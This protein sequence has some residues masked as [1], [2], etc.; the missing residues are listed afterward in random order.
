MFKEG[1][2]LTLRPRSTDEEAISVELS[3]GRFIVETEERDL[4]RLLMLVG[5]EAA[6][7]Q[8]VKLEKMALRL[9]SPSPRQLDWVLS[10]KAKKGMVGIAVDLEVKGSVS[11][12]DQFEA[13]LSGMD[14]RGQGVFGGMATAMIRP[15]LK[16]WNGKRFSLTALLPG[17]VR[18][19]NVRF[20]IG[21]Q[22]RLVASLADSSVTMDGNHH[23]VRGS[24]AHADPT[25]GHRTV[26]K[27][28]PPRTFDVYIVNTGRDERATEILDKHLQLFGSVLAR[29][30]V[31]ELSHEQSQDVLNQHPHL[32]GADPILMVMDSNAPV[33]SSGG[34][35]GFRL[36]LGT[37]EEG[38]ARAESLVR[39]LQMIERESD[40]DDEKWNGVVD[41]RAHQE[42]WQG[43]VQ[44][45]VDIVQPGDG[46]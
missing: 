40:S 9:H 39:L 6:K 18:V 28:G 25:D 20:D 37:S 36:C 23:L 42:R 4:E 26:K 1:L 12:T 15:H 41:E 29:H 19:R 14:I 17:D 16:E 43:V 34:G 11:I 7:A 24:G 32:A 44:M 10:A 21:D 3:D 45:L 2:D 35:Y 30:H 13:V 27:S 8:G 31:Y 5:Q 33:P 46:S 38:V 22:I